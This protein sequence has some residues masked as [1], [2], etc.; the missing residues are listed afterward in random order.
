MADGIKI[1]NIDVSAFKVGSSDCKIYLGDTLLYPQSPSINCSIYY[2]YS[3]GTDYCYNNSS[4]SLTR[5][6]FTTYRKGGTSSNNKWLN[7]TS[8]IV[9]N[10]IVRL[11]DNAFLGF[12]NTLTSVTFSDNLTYIGSGGLLNECGGLTSIVI[13]SGVTFIGTELFYGC[14]NLSSVTVNATT[15]PTVDNITV[16]FSGTSANLKIYVPCDSVAAYKASTSWSPMASKIEAIPDSCPK[17][18]QWVSFS[19]GDTIPQGNVYG[20][21]GNSQTVG[22]VSGGILEIGTD[23]NNCVTFGHGAPTRAPQFTAYF[24]LVSNGTP[25][26]VDSWDDGLRTFIFSDYASNGVEEYYYED[27]TKTMPFDCQLYI[28]A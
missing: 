26:Y 23:S 6:D 27:G 2:T 19:A 25:S 18:L 10:D 16:D 3:D 4:T 7:A 28:Y 14:S 1:G 20:F 11:E 9:G 8:V 24:Y 15:P 21:K 12:S 5:T 17:V 22:L 13:P